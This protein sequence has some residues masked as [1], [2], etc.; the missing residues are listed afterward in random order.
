M[1]DSSIAP[2][3]VNAAAMLTDEKPV[4]P[5]PWSRRT[6]PAAVVKVPLMLTV[7]LVTNVP[8]FT[9]GIVAP[10]VRFRTLSVCPATLVSVPGPFSVTLSK[11]RAVVPLSRFVVKL[12]VRFE[13]ASVPAPPSVPALWFSVPPLTEKVR[14]A[15]IV[16]VPVFVKLGVVPLWLRARFAPLTSI[17]PLL[18]CAALEPLMVSGCWTETVPWL[19]S[20]A[21]SVRGPPAPGRETIVAPAEL[22]SVAPTGMDT[23]AAKAEPTLVSSRVPLFTKPAGT[24]RVEKPVEPSG[25]SRTI[26][27]GAVTNGPFTF[28]VAFVTTVP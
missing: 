12:P 14:P 7:A 17:V 3:F 6:E 27:P 8:W 25:W 18:R 24:L 9:N 19:S 11:P 26:E 23:V 21:C 20:V 5:S 16:I 1:L 13:R 2:L 22:V 15:P 4:V 28:I 10:I